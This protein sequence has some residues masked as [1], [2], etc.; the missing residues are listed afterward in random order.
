M[1]ALSVAGATKFFGCLYARKVYLW[2]GK[3]KGVRERYGRITDGVWL[4][5]QL[6]WTSCT[7]R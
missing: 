3:L 5:I 2:A 6:G 7:A 1:V 4:V